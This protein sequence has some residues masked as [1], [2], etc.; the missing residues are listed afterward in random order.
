MDTIQSSR[1]HQLNEG[2]LIESAQGSD[3]HSSVDHA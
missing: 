3:E 2:C 1:I